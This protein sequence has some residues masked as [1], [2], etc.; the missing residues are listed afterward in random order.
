MKNPRACDSF[1]VMDDLKS[2]AEEINKLRKT[3]KAVVLAHNYQRDEVQEIAD[4]CGDSLALSQIAAKS[5]ADVIVFCGVHFMAESAAILAPDRT[6]LLPNE[7]AGC[8]MADM[9]T[10]EQLVEKK[11]GLHGVPVVCYVNTSAEVKAES[12]ICCTSA[13]AARVVDS[14]PGDEVYM[15][16]DMNLSR[17]VQRRT[18][19]K[20]SYWRGFCPT[21]QYL[22]AAEV[23]ELK[24]SKPGRAVCGAPRMPARGFGPGGRRQEHQRNVRVRKKK[25]GE[26]NHRRDRDGDSLQVAQGESGKGI[27]A[28]LK[29]ARLSEHEGH[30][31]RGRAGRA[32]PH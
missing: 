25:P 23:A 27:C 18:K 26:K 17:Y 16:P 6:V 14:L 1:K 21:H 22:K 11:R 28:R 4:H 20:V 8:P 7:E 31:A 5:T 2:L 3:R 19:K 32:S 9:I 13:N 24:R 12:D 30:D 10:A 29:G 15:I